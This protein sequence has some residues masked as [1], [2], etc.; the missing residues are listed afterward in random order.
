MSKDKAEEKAR[1]YAGITPDVN[2]ID[3]LPN[4]FVFVK[5]KYFS[6]IAGYTQAV[7]DLSTENAQLREAL[8]WRN[9]K[10]ELPDY[11]ERVLIETIHFGTHIA[12]RKHEE[13]FEGYDR[14]FENTTIIGWLPIP[15]LQAKQL[16][17][18]NT[19]DNEK[20]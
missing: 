10:F 18:D 8:R 13:Y 5:E 2:N 15:Q 3:Q 6:F 14:T 16:L 7:T 17:T 4:Q 20:D 1:E 12:W 11:G 19:Q 9:I